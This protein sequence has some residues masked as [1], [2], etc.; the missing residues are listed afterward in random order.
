VTAFA[1]IVTAGEKGRAIVSFTI[2]S[3]ARSQ[4]HLLLVISY[5]GAGLAIGAGRLVTSGFLGPLERQSADAT[6]LMLPLVLMLFLIAGLRTALAIPT[7][8]DANWIFRLSPPSERTTRS[9]TLAVVFV[10]GVALPILM[11]AAVAAVLNWPVSKIIVTCAFDLTIGLVLA[12]VALRH[13]LH[14]PFACEYV[15]EPGTVRSTWLRFVAF[16][17]V[18]GFLGAQVQEVALRSVQ[19]IAIYFS[20]VIVSV[21]VALWRCRARNRPLRFD[22]QDGSTPVE[23]LGLSGASA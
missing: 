22:A 17:A 8:L 14:V 9:S 11:F 16:V 18:L 4:R 6:V 23:T 3:L 2:L 15:P 13:W 7:D 19:G 21:V 5:A 20:V 12:Q 10:I 1:R